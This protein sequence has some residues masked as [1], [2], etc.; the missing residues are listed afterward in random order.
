MKSSLHASPIRAIPPIAF[1]FSLDEMKK[2]R[3]VIT[4][5]L[6]RLSIFYVWIAYG[7]DFTIFYSCNYLAKMG[8]EVELTAPSVQNSKSPSEL[9]GAGYYPVQRCVYCPLFERCACY[10]PFGQCPCCSPCQQIPRLVENPARPPVCF[11]PSPSSSQFSQFFPA[12]CQ[13]MC[14]VYVILDGKEAH[15]VRN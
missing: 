6:W 2:S 15:G 10:S 3:Y 5:S 9:R 11:P 7:R 13:Q 1:P 4:D 8:A 14:F 12:F